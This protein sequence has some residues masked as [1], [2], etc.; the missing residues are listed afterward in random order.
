[1]QLKNHRILLMLLLCYLPTVVM[2][3]TDGG[4]SGFD[5]LRI[6]TGARAVGMGGAFT[7]MLVDIHGLAYNPVSLVGVR[8]MESGFTYLNY[9]AGM[10]AGFVGLNKTMEGI[11][12]FGIGVFYI[13]YGEMRR[14]DVAGNDLGAF[15]PADFAITAA[16]ADSLSFGLRFGA[17][18]R[19]IQSKIDEYA[20]RALAVDL[21][22]IYR[23][24]SQDLN[25]GIGVSNLGSTV[26]AFLD[27]RERLPTAYRLGVSKRLAHLPL[28]LNLDL[29]KYQHEESD[30]FWGLYWALGGEFTITE[31]FFLRW[32]YNSRG[33]ENKVGNDSDRFAG[34]SLGFGIRYGK[35]Q[36][37]Y[38]FSS[39]G[40]VGNMNTFTVMIP[41]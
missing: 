34:V 5:F 3:E 29:I 11:G 13:N 36:L 7:A 35:Y 2:G 31:N 23:I 38:G 12:H 16:Y 33:K 21:G 27:E 6:E 19:Y 1:M 10:N 14:T 25:I 26:D 39:F 40:A 15:Y 17:S 37:D 24:E 4:R 32:G 9:F 22:L 20:S 30:L 41:F 18:I 8:D 28:L